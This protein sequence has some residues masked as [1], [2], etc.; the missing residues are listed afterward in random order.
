MASTM[1][2]WEGL[3][4]EGMESML[5]KENVLDTLHVYLSTHTV[6]RYKRLKHKKIIILGGYA[7]IW[8]CWKMDT[9]KHNFHEILLLFQ[10]EQKD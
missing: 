1:L 10:T 3:E 8:P 5:K 6:Y 9:G 4:G 7:I 2:F